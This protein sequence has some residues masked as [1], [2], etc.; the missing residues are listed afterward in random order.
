MGLILKN[1]GGNGQKRPKTASQS[2][3]GPV[4]PSHGT[5][6]MGPQSRPVMPRF[7]NNVVEMPKAL[8]TNLAL[9]WM[10]DSQHKPKISQKFS[11]STFQGEMPGI[12]F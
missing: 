2:Q 8:G 1:M 7:W 6:P 4:S 9:V 11:L 3:S 5:P 12:K 10:T